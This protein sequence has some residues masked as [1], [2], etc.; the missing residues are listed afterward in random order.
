[1]DK[2]NDQIDELNDKLIKYKIELGR[3]RKILDKAN[4]K[5]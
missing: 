2:F 5:Y 4:I 1:M 3:L